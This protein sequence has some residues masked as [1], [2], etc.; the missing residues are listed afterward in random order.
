MSDEQIT[1]AV[2]T[3]R[4]R[5]EGRLKVTGSARY[6]A[7]VPM[8]GLAHGWVVMA[9][10]S[11][12]RLRD[13]DASA[14]LGMPGVL[15]VLDWR[16]APR[17]NPEAGNYFGPDGSIQ[18]LQDDVIPYAGRPIALV[19]AETPEQARAAAAAL[20]VTY[21]LEPHDV[22][23]HLDHPASRPASTAFGPEAD[24]GDVDAELATSAVVVDQ[25]YRTPEESHSA[26][27][28]HASTAW[29]DDGHLYAVDSNQGAFSV[30]QVLA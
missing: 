10:I 30:S 20:V 16:N 6:A 3:P 26:M 13:L 14:A 15:G 11:R 9:T 12:G 23:L 8:P 24:T 28:P 29:W 18:L 25:R 5:I 27:E 19:V 22:E 17:L 4:P 1:S 7:D 2:G 21:Q